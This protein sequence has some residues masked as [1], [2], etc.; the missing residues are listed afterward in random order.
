MTSRR[1]LWGLVAATAAL[2]LAWAACLGVGNDEAYHYLFALHRDWSYYDHP[3]MMPAGG[4]APGGWGGGSQP[5]FLPSSRDGGVALPP[6]PLKGG[7]PAPG[8][9]VGRAGGGAFLSKY[10]GVFLPVGV[11]LS[12]LIEPTARRWLRR[13]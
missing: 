10:R 11:S 1:A 9:A 3:P 2:R 5:H 4:R 6:P 7:P 13:P 8:R 12:L